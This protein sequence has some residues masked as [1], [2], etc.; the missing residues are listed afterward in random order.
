MAVRTPMLP[1]VD[2]WFDKTV[3]PART[4]WSGLSPNRVYKSP[5]AYAVGNESDPNGLCGDATQ[6]VVEKF[7]TTFSETW[8]PDGY[9][10]CVV[11]W[12]GLVANHMAN[13]MLP[14]GKSEEQE[15]RY[16]GGTLIRP[17]VKPGRLLG[18][19]PTFAPSTLTEAELLSL[20]VY[21][22]YYKRRTN[23]G[24]WWEELDGKS[25]TLKVGLYTHFM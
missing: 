9:R 13:V 19:S 10:L 21:D 1:L 3:V 8:T 20:H 15:F 12:S 7:E 23:L 2:N 22:L 24:T 16:Q 11:L 4:A 25:G 5:R 14:R 6:F 17:V 18:G